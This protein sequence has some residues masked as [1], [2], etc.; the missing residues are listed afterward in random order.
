[1]FDDILG[2][3]PKKLDHDPT[4]MKDMRDYQDELVEERVE[5]RHDTVKRNISR[6]TWS[7]GNRPRGVWKT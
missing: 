4:P 6:S 7:T 5:E 1:M 3:A 2:P